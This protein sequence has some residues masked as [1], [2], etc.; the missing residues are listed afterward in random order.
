MNCS[1]QLDRLIWVSRNRFR[2]LMNWL[3]RKNFEKLY[4]NNRNRIYGLA[5]RLVGFDKTEAEDVVQETFLR[6]Y[7]SFATY[8]EEGK[9]TSWLNRICLNVIWEKQRRTQ[10]FNESIYP[11]VKYQSGISRDEGPE[12]RTATS[13]R[14]QMIRRII[15]SISYPLRE[16]LI[17][18]HLEGYSTEEVSEMMK[19]HPGTVRSRLGRA[20]QAFIELY[21]M[22]DKT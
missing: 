22:E 15:N 14:Q 13:E 6:A 16:V 2:I 10:F 3:Q 7:R 11:E 1:K 8:R 21:Q 19:L 9:V 12:N 4:R 17:L 18:R 20:R 5:W